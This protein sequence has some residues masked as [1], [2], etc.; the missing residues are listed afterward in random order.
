MTGLTPNGSVSPVVLPVL[1]YV[2]LT[3]CC[4]YAFLRGGRPERAGATLA[5]AASLLSTLTAPTAHYWSEASWA[6]LIIDCA[7]F[8]GAAVISLRT[9][10]FWPMWFA[11]F[12]LVGAMTHLATAALPEYT[13][14]AYA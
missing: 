9:D 10:R 13:P 7:T 3:L 2:Y 1:Y 5:I 14:K 12:C 8:V 6:L 11:G 4:A